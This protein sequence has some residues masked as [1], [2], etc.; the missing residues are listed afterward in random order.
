MTIFLAASKQASSIPEGQ[1]TSIDIVHD[2]EAEPSEIWMIFADWGCGIAM[3][4][5]N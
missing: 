4:V 5:I 2:D 3:G 1:F